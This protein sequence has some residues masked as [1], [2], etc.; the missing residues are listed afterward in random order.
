MSDFTTDLV[1]KDLSGR[2]R[3]LV[4]SFSF[5]LGTDS[6][7]CVF[8]VPVGFITDGASVPRVL[9]SLISPWSGKHSKAA[10][11]HD[12]LYRSGVV[13]RL[14]AD[15]IFL[16]AMRVLKVNRFTALTMYIAVRL[17]GLKAWE[18]YNEQ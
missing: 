4:E 7:A 10:V 8:N 5:Y 16:E 12:Y 2:H 9:H 15:V 17:F 3:E 1:C 11:L 13:S 18:K 6:K 14:I